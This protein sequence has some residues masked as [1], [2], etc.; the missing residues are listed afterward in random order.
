MSSFQLA[1]LCLK[2]QHLFSWGWIKTKV[3][4][5]A[6]KQ[7]QPIPD[8]VR[9]LGADLGLGTVEPGGWKKVGR[10]WGNGCFVFLALLCNWLMVL[11]AAAAASFWDWLFFIDLECCIMVKAETPIRL[12][13]TVKVGLKLCSLGC[14]FLFR[15]PRVVWS[16][17]GGR[18]LL[19]KVNLAFLEV[20]VFKDLLW[21]KNWTRFLQSWLDPHMKPEEE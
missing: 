4:T 7:T 16:P 2:L 1:Q 10:V 14:F 5:V 3:A 21:L 20:G 6:R 17:L 19:N 13:C 9:A 15:E 8:A 11:F 12:K 18:T